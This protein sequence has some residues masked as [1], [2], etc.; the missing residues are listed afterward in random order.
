MH[1]HGHIGVA[2]LAYAPVGYLLLATEH[3]ALAVVGLVGILAVEPLP[4]HD[5]W[6]PGLR[7][8]GTSH[9]LLAAVVVGGVLGTLGWVVGARVAS[10]LARGDCAGVAWLAGLCA[11]DGPSLAAIGAAVG[12]GGVLVHLLGDALTVAGIRPLLPVSRWRCSLSSVRADDALANTG[13]L[14]AGVCALVGVV[15]VAGG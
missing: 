5:H 4:D 1:R 14:V 10:L 11:V 2:L 9:S 6:L 13:L 12:S 15:V 3:A 7:H 8:R